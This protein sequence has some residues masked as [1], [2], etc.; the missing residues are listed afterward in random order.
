MVRFRI[1]YIFSLCSSLVIIYMNLSGV[2]TTLAGSGTEV[3]ANGIGTSASFRSL[4]GVATA[5]DGTVYVAEMQSHLIRKIATSGAVTT[6]AGTASSGYADGV[7]TLAVF[8]YPY[9]I[10]IDT[11]GV[12]YISDSGNARIRVMAT[13]GVVTT[14]AGSGT[15]SYAN[16]I[17]TNAR[18]NQPKSIFITSARTIYVGD[19]TNARVRKVLTSGELPSHLWIFC[20]KYCVFGRCGDNRCW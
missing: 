8:S 19:S 6:A 3:V 5:T 17:G 10:T 14:L 1:M 20:N 7:T 13:S 11:L 4:V 2:V 16:G 15:A 9:G 18:F 12:A